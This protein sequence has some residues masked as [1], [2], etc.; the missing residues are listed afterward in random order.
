MKT[1]DKHAGWFQPV[2]AQHRHFF[3]GET[4]LCKRY[5]QTDED[6]TPDD[7]Y[8]RPFDNDCVPCVAALVRRQTHDN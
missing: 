6:L 5:T 8:V 4:S 7:G 1:N 3:E 2:D